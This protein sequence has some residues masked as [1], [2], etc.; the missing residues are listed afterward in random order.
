VRVILLCALGA[1]IIASP[2]GLRPVSGQTPARDRPVRARPA[3]AEPERRANGVIRGRV[4]ADGPDA[5]TPL[6]KV[7]VELTRDG[8][9]DWMFT[10]S[11]GLFEFPEL[12]GGHYTVLADK[13]GYATTHYGAAGPLEAPAMID[14]A[15]GGHEELEIRLPKGAV[16]A[17]HVVDDLGDT[18]V[19][20]RVTVNAIRV[21]GTQQR[22]API[23]QPPVETDDQGAFRVGG[24]PAGRYLL[25]VAARDREQSSVISFDLAGTPPLRRIGAGRSFYP[26]SATVGEA[27]P[28]E[29][30]PGEERL[31]VGVSTAPFRP[32][33]LT[34]AVATAPDPALKGATSPA[35]AIR[36]GVDPSAIRSTLPVRVVFANQDGP[37]FVAQNG[38]YAFSPLGPNPASTTGEIDPGSW[39]VI[40]RKGVDGAIARVTLAPGETQSTLL[41]IRPASRFNGRLVFEGSTRRTEAAA[42]YLDVIGAGQDSSV[43]LLFLLPGGRVP[44]KPDGSFSLVGLLGTVEFAVAAPPGWTVSRISAGD[45]DLLGTSMTFEGGEVVT[46]ARVVLSDRVGEISGSVLEPDARP[47]AGCR[48]AVFPAGTDVTFNRYR[49]QLAQVDRTGRFVMRGLPPGPYAVAAVREVDASNWT[50]PESLARLRAAA[51]TVTLAEHETKALALQCGGSQ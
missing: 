40:A 51:I 14:L 48:I 30:K 43:S 49:M 2:A 13:S 7:R 27:I 28:I 24:L 17:G 8:T 36:L 42:V 4:I 5:S 32:A 25:S 29:L 3:D 39:A 10:D 18:L 1:T 38:D 21:E 19:G 47:A 37:E 20:A 22:L 31:D 9:T 34:V 45:R 16:I 35:E 41:N 33:T 15:E 11:S 23:S 44:V 6:A 26:S 50:A 46:D 12:P